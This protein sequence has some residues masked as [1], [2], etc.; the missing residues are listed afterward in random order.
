MTRLTREVRFA[1][2]PLDPLPSPDGKVANAYAAHPPPHRLGTFLTLAVTVQGPLDPASQYLL[3]IKDIDTAVRTYALPVFR[4]HLAQPT[5]LGHAALA[6]VAPLLDQ[7]LGNP[8]R[9]VRVVA[10]SLHLSPYLRLQRLTP[11]LP[12]VRLSCKFEFS[13][14]HRLHNPALSDADNVATFGKC[15][16]P[17]GHGH[18]YELQVTLRDEPHKLPTLQTL[19]T[20]VND[21]VIR[22]Y[23]HKHLNEEVPEFQPLSRGGRGI[24]PSVENIAA[25]AYARLKPVFP[26]QLASVTV[27]ETPKTWAEY[28]EDA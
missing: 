2:H 8:A 9:G 27:W 10:I 1:L 20:A 23:D 17:L 28:S 15:N 7:A 13:A 18:N 19:E 6:K 16:N 14:A 26:T 24:I 22:A 5:D 3:N 11:E 25:A 12:M 4:R 21:T